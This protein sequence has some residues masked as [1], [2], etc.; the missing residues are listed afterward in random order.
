MMYDDVDFPLSGFATQFAS[1][2]DLS[3]KPPGLEMIEKSVDPAKKR[4]RCLAA[5]MYVL[6]GLEVSLANWLKVE[7]GVAAYLY[8]IHSRTRGWL[9]SPLAF[10]VQE[11]ILWST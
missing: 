2:N 7:D 3:L 10:F 4:N 8:K 1:E 9:V 11:F 5:P 6:D